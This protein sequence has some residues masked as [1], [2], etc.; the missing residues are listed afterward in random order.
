RRSQGRFDRVLVGVGKTPHLAVARGGAVRS[1][2]AARMV[3]AVRPAV[4]SL[5]LPGAHRGGAVCGQRVTALQSR[6]GVYSR[7]WCRASGV[8]VSHSTIGELYEAG[9]SG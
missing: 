9:V 3:R 7:V 2:T 8:Q 1:Q 4:R 5:Q 6:L